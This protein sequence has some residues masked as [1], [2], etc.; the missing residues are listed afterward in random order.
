MEGSC[1]WRGRRNARSVRWRI[2][3]M[4]R[5][6]RGVRW[7]SIRGRRATKPF[8]QRHRATENSTPSFLVLL[9]LFLCLCVSV[10]KPEFSSWNFQN[11]VAAHQGKDYVGGPGSEH[12]RELADVAHGFE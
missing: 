1:A 5:T 12:G 7:R 10:V 2:F 6:R 8:P 9:V 11:Q 3:A 4:R